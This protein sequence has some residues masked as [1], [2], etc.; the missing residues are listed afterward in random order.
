MSNRPPN[1]DLGRWR[2]SESFG[3]AIVEVLLQLGGCFIYRI[4]HAEHVTGCRLAP[5]G[6]CRLLDPLKK[7]KKPLKRIHGWVEL[8]VLCVPGSDVRLAP[9]GAVPA[10]ARRVSAALRASL[11][12]SRRVAIT[13]RLSGCQMAARRSDPRVRAPAVSKCLTD[14]MQTQIHL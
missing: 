11:D 5:L 4:R 2:A 9:A 8:R 6:I 14:T 12:Q 1:P 3:G 13:E 10:G 7:K